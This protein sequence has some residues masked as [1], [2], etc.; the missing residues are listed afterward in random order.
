LTAAAALATTV[1]PAHAGTGLL[2]SPYNGTYT[3]QLF[4]NFP[5]DTSSTATYNLTGADQSTLTGTS[6]LN[7]S[8]SEPGC[9]DVSGDHGTVTETTGV[10]YTIN[11]VVTLCPDA[12]SS[13][14]SIEYTGTGAYT[15]SQGGVTVETGVS[16]VV[17]TAYG[18]GSAPPSLYGTLTITYT[19][20]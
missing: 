4:S 18:P 7:G 9:Q 20:S 8:Q 10:T 15:L 3:D 11:D 12:T 5:N 6:T 2:G 19:S 16:H 14:G 1:L 13:P 17:A